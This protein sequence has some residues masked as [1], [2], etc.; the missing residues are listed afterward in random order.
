MHCSPPSERDSSADATAP[1]VK[2][3]INDLI[4]VLI[5]DK[6]PEGTHGL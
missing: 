3:A 4:F 6:L 5:K 1:E 2:I